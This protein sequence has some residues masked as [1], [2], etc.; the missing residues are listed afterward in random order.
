MW[1]DEEWPALGSGHDDDG[2]EKG[3]KEGLKGERR[4]YN[5]EAL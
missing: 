5:A 4:T 3:S 2:L 1:K